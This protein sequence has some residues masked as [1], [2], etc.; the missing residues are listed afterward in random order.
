ME[1]QRQRVVA[2]GCRTRPLFYR[3]GDSGDKVSQRSDAGGSRSVIQMCGMP[4]AFPGVEWPFLPYWGGKPGWGG[5]GQ[6]S[7]GRAEIVIS[8]TGPHMLKTQ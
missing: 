2:A 4:S 7:V 8:N 3:G 5:P 1:A 6:S